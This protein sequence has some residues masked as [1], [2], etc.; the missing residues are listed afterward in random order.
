MRKVTIT[1]EKRSWKTS[2]IA[3]ITD[4]FVDDKAY[5]QSRSNGDIMTFEIDEQSHRI[6]AITNQTGIGIANQTNRGNILQIPQGTEDIDIL[7][8]VKPEIA[9][10]QIPT[11][12]IISANKIQNVKVQTTQ[13]QD[14]RPKLNVG[15]FV[16]GLIFYI[17]PG[18]IYYN[19]VTRKQK[20][21]DNKHT[22]A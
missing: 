4:I 10:G 2:V 3:P 5:A 19:S 6:Q 1:R 17:F 15:L 9:R 20:E 21:W 16:L 14:Q 22:K 8:T 13:L 11:L 7:L 18:I 12:I